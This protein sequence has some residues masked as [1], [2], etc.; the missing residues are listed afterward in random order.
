MQ[1][2]FQ[3]TAASC[4]NPRFVNFMAWRGCFFFTYKNK[5]N[6]QDHQRN[7]IRTH[8]LTNKTILLEAVHTTKLRPDLHRYIQ[9]INITARKFNNIKS[10]LY[11]CNNLLHYLSI[12]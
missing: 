2:D 4:M 10:H 6:R 8:F 11:I 3:I 5:T 9:K 7:Q 12:K 1:I